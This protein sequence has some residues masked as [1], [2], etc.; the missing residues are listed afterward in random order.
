MR[1]SRP[2]NL[3]IISNIISGFAQGISML[4]IP[5]YFVSIL[6]SPEKLTLMYMLTLVGS[7]FW[8]LYSGT[9]I[10]KYARKSI[11]LF[12]SLIGGIILC[13]A[14]LTGFLY[15]TGVPT[16]IVVIVFM[17]TA[18][19]NTIYYPALYAFA[20]EVSEPSR[21]GKVNS[22]LEIQSQAMTIA[23]GGVGAILLQG[24]DI[25][26]IH[27]PMS[28]GGISIPIS[29]HIARWSLSRIFMV[30]GLTYFVAIAL[31]AMV[32]YAPHIEKHKVEGSV[33]ERFKTGNAFLKSH[34][35]VLIFGIS[36]LSIFVF[37]LLHFNTLVPIYIVNHLHSNVT[38]YA[39]TD[40]FYA[41]GAL[42]AGVW[43]RQIF[44]NV[45][46]VKAILILI[47]IT[48]VTLTICALSTS[49]AIYFAFSFMLGV[50]NAGARVL[51][52]T[53]L[54]HHVPNNLIGRVN[55]VLFML[56]TLWRLGL[57]MIFSLAFFS[58]GDNVTWALLICVLFLLLNFIMLAINYKG[59]TTK[60]PDL[61]LDA[62]VKS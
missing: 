27:I 43:V 15:D 22:L 1:S 41:I 5:W 8:G 49:N 50:T 58:E 13:G 57:A 33:W 3:L 35:L 6:H 30:D 24:I 55:S 26:A 19:I 40:V 39:L 60:Y 42:L 16:Y 10:D 14:S 2:L 9:L 59:L 37:L 45:N 48:W 56:G 7:V 11:F 44:R 32:K 23:S 36:S 12:F 61:S 31:I 38:I 21:Y 34:P 28:F 4:A 29:L 51:R 47:S 20:Q 18:Y 53:Y 54:F 52:I 25:N 17:A 46:T 62:S